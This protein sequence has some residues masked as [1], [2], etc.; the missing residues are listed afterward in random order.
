MGDEGFQRYAA[1]SADAAM[2]GPALHAT[3]ETSPVV[4]ERVSV[5]FSGEGSGQGALSW[6]QREIWLAM[7]R[8]GWLNLG[9]CIPLPP[10]RT[11]QDLADEL[12]FMMGRFQSLRTRLRFDT[13]GRPTQELS[14]SGEIVLEVY[15]AA[16]GQDPGAVAAAVEAGYLA[17]PRD[18]VN[19][20]PLRVGVV[21]HD[22]APAFLVVITCHLVTD[23]AGMVVL[24]RETQERLSGPVTGA[25]SLDL[26]RWQASP[27]GRR[28]SAVA[29]QHLERTMRSV[30]PRR[31]PTSDD[32]REPRHWTG[33]LDSPALAAAL[34]AVS[35]RTGADSSSILMALFAIAVSR[36]GLLRPAVIRPLVSNRFRPGLANGVL[37]LVQSGMCVFDVADRTVDD[38]VRQARRSFIAANKHGYFDPDGELALIERIAAEQGP[39]A[40]R[41]SPYTWAFFNDR[42]RSARAESEEL[43]TPE[44]AEKLRNATTF[45]WTQKKQN[46]YEPLF[47]HLEEEGGGLQ[48]I[49]AADTHHVSPA[50]NEGLARDIEALGI[51]AAFDGTL[52][53][54]VTAGSAD[55]GGTRDT[56]ARLIP[57]S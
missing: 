43:L 41:W 29:L 37:N 2:P 36:R 30:I 51:A 28:Q 4:A 49:V 5:A 45:Q 22:G 25:Q 7:Q 34:P 40:E 53:T 15:D 48:L 47:L 44:L 24:S 18:F 13:D 10:G 9:G 52:S 32:P 50:D 8:Q 27:A 39:G 33:R 19:E 26:A 17:A 3:P 20:W 14:A 42:R 21:R 6:G 12:G 55:A 23:G 16:A 1:G 54:G 56:T 31:L 38:V 35:E 11:V 46:P 57:G